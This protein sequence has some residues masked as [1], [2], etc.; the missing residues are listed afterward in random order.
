MLLMDIN[1]YVWYQKHTP[2]SYA[3]MTIC[4]VCI[5][6]HAIH[7]NTLFDFMYIMLLRYVGSQFEH[8]NENIQKLVEQ[9]KQKIRYAWETSTSPLSHQ[10]M[11]DTETSKQN[12]WILMHIHLELC[13]ISR[14]LNTIFGLKMVTQV[15]AFHV[16]TVQIIYE[17]YVMMMMTD[18]DDFTQKLIDLFGK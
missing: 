16:F 4:A 9:K 3:I 8:V 6:N 2:R 18:A 13:S 7:I 1:D 11:I 10:H 15:V 14:Q 12:I 17:C 5:A